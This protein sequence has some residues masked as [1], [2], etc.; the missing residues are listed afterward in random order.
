MVYFKVQLTSEAAPSIS[1]VKANDSLSVDLAET[2]YAKTVSGLAPETAYTIYC[3]AADDE[4]V[5]NIQT[6]LTPVSFT[7]IGLPPTIAVQPQILSVCVGNWTE[8]SVSATS[9][10]AIQYQWY[11]NEEMITGANSDTLTF[12][13]T[14]IADNAD[15]FCA[16]TNDYATIYTDTVHL[17][18]DEIPYAGADTNF[19]VCVGTSA[20][21]LFN[22]LPGADQDGIFFDNSQ[23]GALAR[24][25]FYIN[26][27]DPGSY[28][29]T[30]VIDGGACD[31][32]FSVMN[33]TVEECTGIKNMFAMNTSAYFGYNGALQ[34]NSDTKIE[35]VLIFNLLGQNVFEKRINN[36]VSSDQIENDLPGG[37]YLIKMISKTDFITLKVLK[38]F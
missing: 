11:K 16:L 28:N 24:N 37:I 34:I 17:T 32:D 19:I 10:T 33:V 20:I 3:I 9:T 15:Y 13:T 27:V 4:T 35:A 31:N 36:S 26:Q 14:S 18:V 12:N 5:P 29:I 30:Y 1:E 2:N 38:Q 25:I 21:D 8:L 22:Y 7:T 6:S 23:S